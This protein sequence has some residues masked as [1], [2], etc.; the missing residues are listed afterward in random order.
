MSR[1]LTPVSSANIARLVNE[2]QT[3]GDRFE[4]RGNKSWLPIARAAAIL[5]SLRLGIN[6][7]VDL[8]GSGIGTL[9]IELESIAD[10]NEGLS[11]WAP[12]TK[13]ASLLEGIR[14]GIT[15]I[16]EEAPPE[17]WFG[18]DMGTGDRTIY[19]ARHA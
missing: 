3:I 17:N 1:K 19:G 5:E 2:L 15:T 6:G 11:A 13:A 8:S 4:K 9:I 10:H 7:Q 18:I 14:I 12:V 16:A